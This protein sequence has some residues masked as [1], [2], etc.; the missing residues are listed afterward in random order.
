MANPRASARQYF[1][2][3][4][5][6][7]SNRT[8]LAILRAAEEVFKARGY[9]AATMQAVADSAGVSLPTVYVYFRSK[10]ALVRS[11]AD[12]VTGS[13]DLSVAHALAESDPRRQLEIGAGILRRLH[14]RSEVIVDVLRTAARGDPTLAREW[15]RWQDG[16]LAAVRAVAQSLARRGALR[17]GVDVR[18]ATDVLYTVGGP[19]T[20]RQLVRERGWTPAR[21]ERW[22]AEAGKQLLVR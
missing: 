13:E 1:S 7:Q 9:N 10:P 22:L 11:L 5:Q 4:R 15:R 19:E 18:I 16:H 20:F 8:R 17:E 12:L 14:E 6:E 21:Y 2:P 3:E